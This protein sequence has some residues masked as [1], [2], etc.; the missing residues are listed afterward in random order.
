MNRNGVEINS[1]CG[2]FL[3]HDHEVWIVKRAILAGLNLT[4]DRLL[5]IDEHVSRN[6]FA[7]LRVGEES[8]HVL[9]NLGFVDQSAIGT[10]SM[11]ES[12]QFPGSG[13]DLD[14][15]LADME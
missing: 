6:D 11:F 1:L 2:V 5:K 14:T 13:S 9:I 7:G 8:L 3:A 15:S 12:E 10:D 4:D